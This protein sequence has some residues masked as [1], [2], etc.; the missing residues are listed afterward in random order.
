MFISASGMVFSALISLTPA[1]AKRLHVCHLRD[2][3]R[4]SRFPGLP[5][6]TPP[7]LSSPIIYSEADD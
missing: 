5:T 1:I 3:E 4:R 7:V 6:R 2:I